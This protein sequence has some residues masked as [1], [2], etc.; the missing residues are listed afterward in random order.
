MLRLRLF[1][2]MLTSLFLA[3]AF[4]LLSCS[5]DPPQS[6]T[7]EPTG[8]TK[9][10]RK[11]PLFP[12]DREGPQEFYVTTSAEL[13]TVLDNTYEPSL[14]SGDTIRLKASEVFDLGTKSYPRLDDLQLLIVGDTPKPTIK[15]Y[16]YGERSYIGI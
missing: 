5:E 10:S 7:A 13:D 6:P 4:M 16:Q 14:V 9:S 15:S 12:R 8:S 1:L 11:K 2:Y 3:N